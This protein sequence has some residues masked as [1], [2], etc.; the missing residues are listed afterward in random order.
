[1]TAAVD[2]QQLTVATADHRI[3]TILSPKGGAGKTTIATNLAVALARRHPRQVVLV[4][5]D[6]QFGDVAG[7]LRLTPTGTFADIARA[8]PID[9]AALKLQ[10]TPHHTG[11]FVLCAPLDP[12]AADDITAEQV[13]AVLRD[14]S[15][16]FR[17]VVVDTDPGLGE[18]VLSALDA[19]T[20]MVLVCGTDVP[21]VRGL[22]KGLEALDT[23]G[24][25]SQRRH[26]VLNRAD[27]RVNLPPQEIEKSIGRPVDVP[28][29]SS[30]DVVIGTNDGIPVVEAGSNPALV[31]AFEALADRVDDTDTDDAGARARMGRFRRRQS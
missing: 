20:D 24:M 6:L 4:D 3:I 27:A 7:C 2:E 10:L 5:I 11:L 12:A 14:L 9:S 30:R 15:R 13:Y 8:W 1:M 17:F 25:T 23:I 21:S 18:R 22:R 19:S 29:P 26:F 31:K 16:S 28:L